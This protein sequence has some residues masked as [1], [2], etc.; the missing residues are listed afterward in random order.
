M[1]RKKSIPAVR[2]IYWSLLIFL[3]L[4]VL[5]LD[6]NSF[7]GRHRKA[8]KLN[9]MKVELNDIIAKNDSLRHEIKELQTNPEAAEKVGRE[10][11]GLIKPGEKI[12]R[13]ISPAE[14]ENG[15]KSDKK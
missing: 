2:V 8:S 15:K 5:V 14:G 10:R 9:R 3:L 1:Q 6:S 11:Y 7:V 4:W 12:F 13:F